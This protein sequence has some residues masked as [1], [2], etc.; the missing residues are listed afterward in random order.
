MDYLPTLGEKWPHPRGNVGKY[1]LHGAFGLWY[2]NCNYKKY[3]FCTWI[4]WHALQVVLLSNT[5]P[6]INR[7]LHSNVLRV[8]FS[9][10]PLGL[11]NKFLVSFG[12]GFCLNGLSVKFQS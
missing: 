5:L 2:S 6:K 1:S 12:Q 10:L 3:N 8:S 4:V 9:E 11:K 7:L